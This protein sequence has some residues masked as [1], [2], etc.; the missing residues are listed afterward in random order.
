MAIEVFNRFEKKYLLDTDTF[1][2]LQNRL[3]NHMK[4]D[5]YNEDQETYTISNIYYDTPDHH[6]IRTSLGKPNYKEKLRLRAY[7]TPTLDSKVYVE[8]KKK[9]NGLVNKRRSTLKLQEAYTFLSSGMIPKEQPWHNRQVLHEI[10]YILQ[11]HELQPALYL[12]YDRRAYFGVDQS[13]LRIS[14]DRNIRTR[15]HDLAL[16][17]GEQGAL[18]IENSQWI[19]EIKVAKNMPL[20]LCQ[21]LSEYQI[22]PISFSKYGTEYKKTLETRKISPPVYQ[23]LTPKTTWSYRAMANA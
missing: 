11:T 23:L 17:S 4:L 9:V 22:Y 13:D 18:L 19:M 10:E 2:Q 5:D 3:L 7:G 15:R 16:E 12:A 1:E 21:L 6:V 8:I 14:F 20:W